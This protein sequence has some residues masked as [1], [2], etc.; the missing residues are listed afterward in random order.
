VGDAQKV[1][2]VAMHL[3]TEEAIKIVESKPQK[4][5]QHSS[6]EEEELNLDVK[7]PEMKSFLKNIDLMEEDAAQVP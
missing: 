1:L 2:E 5:D 4:E 6:E 3:V 7:N